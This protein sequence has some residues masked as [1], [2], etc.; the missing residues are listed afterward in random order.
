MNQEYYRYLKNTKG[1]T[2]LFC[3]IISISSVVMWWSGFNIIS[4][5][6]DDVVG[7]ALKM[8]GLFLV[9]LPLVNILYSIEFLY[10]MKLHMSF[11]ISNRFNIEYIKLDDYT[12]YREMYTKVRNLNISIKI[13]SFI[14]CI[15]YVLYTTSI[16]FYKY[17]C[18]Y[19]ECIPLVVVVL[20][21]ILYTYIRF[22]ITAIA[23]T[24]KTFNSWFYDV[25]VKDLIIRY[26]VDKEIVDKLN[27]EQFIVILTNIHKLIKK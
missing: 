22:E 16:N 3:A 21:V 2:V 15:V 26:G 7:R 20:G 11:I 14:I 13:V 4:G 23:N 17:I 9:L 10:Y 24:N 19:P 6:G 5:I 8:L 1:Q 12:K 18:L 27:D 25:Y